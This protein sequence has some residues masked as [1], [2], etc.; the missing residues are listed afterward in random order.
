MKL[1]LKILLNSNGFTFLVFGKKANY[2]LSI[3]YLVIMSWE[4][5]RPNDVALRRSSVFRFLIT[6]FLITLFLRFYTK[7][8][9]FTLK[10]WPK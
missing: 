7:C 3:V 1:V 8:E 10:Q 4:E 2:L 9:L 5:K 6:S